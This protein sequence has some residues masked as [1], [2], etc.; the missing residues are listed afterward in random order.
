MKVYIKYFSALREITQI[1]EEVLEVQEACTVMD[2]LHHISNKY[3]EN[4][5]HYLFDPKTHEP[6]PYLQFFVEETP[7]SELQGFATTL[8]NGCTFAIIPLVGGG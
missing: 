2:V 5:T 4:A 7:I 8:T 1:K 3:G 6:R